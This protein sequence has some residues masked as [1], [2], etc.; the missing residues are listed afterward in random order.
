[1]TL[2]PQERTKIKE[3]WIKALKG[4]TMFMQDV[5]EETSDYWLNILDKE[6]EKQKGDKEMLKAQ[7]KEAK[8]LDKKDRE[9]AH[10]NADEALLRYINDAEIMDLYEDIA[11]W[12][13]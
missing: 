4:N 12:Y 3:E 10:C 2:S 9:S 5:Y 1:M 11:K 8:L 6:L 7:L 13:A